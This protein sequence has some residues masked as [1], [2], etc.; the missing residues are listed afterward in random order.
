M[1]KNISITELSD[2][3]KSGQAEII[4]VREPDEYE[5][6]RIK[7]GKLIP[8]SE[9]TAR[10]GEINWQKTVVFYCRTGARSSLAANY[11]ACQGREAFNLSGGIKAFYEDKSFGDLEI[12]ANAEEI[13][14]YLA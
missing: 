13:N 5:I 10:Q 6:I 14:R 7:E 3:I 9:L 8:G 1:P 12:L 4:D 2:L 11:F